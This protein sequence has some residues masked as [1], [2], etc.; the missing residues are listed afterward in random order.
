[1]E[2]TAQARTESLIESYYA[3]FNAG[4]LKGMISLLDKDVRHDINQGESE[5]GIE[6]FQKFLDRMAENYQERIHDI[7]IMASADGKRAACEYQVSGTYLK[8]DPGLPSAHG[9]RYTI[10]GGAFFT[11]VN[12]KIARVTNYYNLP[13]WLNAV[14]AAK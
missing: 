4:D 11:V 9:Q 12:G 8:A 7:V 2:R 6:A 5:H 10:A 1:M 3:R 14:D 13:G